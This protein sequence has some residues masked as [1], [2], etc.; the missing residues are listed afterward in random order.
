MG[1]QRE[2]AQRRPTALWDVRGIDGI[3]RRRGGRHLSDHPLLDC[4]AVVTRWE[5]QCDLEAARR[6]MSWPPCVLLARPEANG[7]A[8]L[9]HQVPLPP[10]TRMV[11][12]APSGIARS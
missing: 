1:R 9:H 12:R 4:D 5:R 3:G 11:R 10:V 6:R 7:D 8:H 2:P